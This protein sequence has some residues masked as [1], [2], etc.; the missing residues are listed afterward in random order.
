MCCTG[1][2]LAIGLRALASSHEVR[3][4]GPLVLD[5]LGRPLDHMIRFSS[6]FVP[7]YLFHTFYAP[8]FFAF[9]TF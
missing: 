4:V 6:I 1:R 7:Y 3:W 8:H 2:P 5:T 9:H